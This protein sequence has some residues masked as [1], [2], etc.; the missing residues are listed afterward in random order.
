M[1]KDPSK[2]GIS[3]SASTPEPVKLD[4]ANCWCLCFG[5]VFLPLLSSLQG[6]MCLPLNLKCVS[7]EGNIA[8]SYWT[9]PEFRI[10][11]CTYR[12]AHAHMEHWEVSCPLL[13][14][15]I[16]NQWEPVW[17]L[18]EWHSAEENKEGQ[19]AIKTLRRSSLTDLCTVSVSPR[20]HCSGHSGFFYQ[21]WRLGLAF[22]PLII[23]DAP[24]LAM[25]STFLYFCTCL[26]LAFI[27]QMME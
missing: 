22:V 24:K 8:D 14:S 2:S 6:G 25:K 17:Y 21:V 10:S 11:E 7:I 16:V 27:E 26:K 12:T 9:R 20:W 13:A 18:R 15:I 1:A 5:C 3:L 4:K 19:R 23:T